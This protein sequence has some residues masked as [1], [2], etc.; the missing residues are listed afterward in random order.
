MHQQYQAR[1]DRRA[2]IGYIDRAKFKL[3]VWGLYI[4]LAEYGH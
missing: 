2:I 4:V 3:H 1:A